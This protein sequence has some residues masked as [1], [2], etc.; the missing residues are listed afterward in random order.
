MVYL[1]T[2]ET[3]FRHAERVPVE[4]LRLLSSAA[5]GAAGRPDCLSSDAP[6]VTPSGY[7]PAGGLSAGDTVLLGARPVE[8]LWAGL[9]PT[10]AGAIRIRAASLGPGEPFCDIVV[11]ATQR[12]VLSSPAVEALCGAPEALVE[13]RDLLHLDG[14]EEEVLALS[15]LVGLVFAAQEFLPVAG[16]SLASL[17]PARLGPGSALARDLACVVPGVR[18]PGFAS[19]YETGIPELN[20]REARAA[21]ASGWAGPRAVRRAV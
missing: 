1:P 21:V 16:L 6:I 17:A 11:G 5:P 9:V 20:R 13:A 2:T 8:I 7:R 12:V 15:G 4:P 3:G 14:V 19:R 10:G 18:Y